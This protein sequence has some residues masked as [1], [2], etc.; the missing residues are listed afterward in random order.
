MGPW[1]ESGS[2]QLGAP[3]GP[4]CRKF[5][6]GPTYLLSLIGSGLGHAILHK[7]LNG[8]YKGLTHSFHSCFVH[9]HRQTEPLLYLRL[10]AD[11]GDKGIS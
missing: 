10:L 11:G 5:T 9:G 2:M 6:A 4:V 3:C 1:L 8:S 7:Q